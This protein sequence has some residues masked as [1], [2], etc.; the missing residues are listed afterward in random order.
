MRRWWWWGSIPRMRL[1]ESRPSRASRG[2]GRRLRGEA[3]RR[4][5]VAVSSTL[6]LT[7]RLTLRLKVALPRRVE[8]EN[9]Q[10]VLLRLVR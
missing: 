3:L 10:W 6:M 5:G 8:V 7:L 1:V 2:E 4:R 9:A